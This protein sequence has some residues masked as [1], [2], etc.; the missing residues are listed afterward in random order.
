LVELEL[1]DKLF[2]ITGD[3]AGNNGTL[4][5]S[6]YD[7]L[8][9]NYEDIIQGVQPRMR[10]HGRESWIRCLAHVINLICDDILTKQKAGTAK[11][12]KKLMEAWERQF[13]GNNYQIPGD[14]SRSTIAQ[15]EVCQPLDVTKLSERTRLAQDAQLQDPPTYLR[16]RYSIELLLRYD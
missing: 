11:E 9:E 7:R 3:N 15:S 1:E 14:S 13:N 4:C 12:A 5:D 8:R 6:V 2:S 10:F 16:R